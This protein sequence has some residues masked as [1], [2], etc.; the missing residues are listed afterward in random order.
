MDI[1]SLKTQGQK[2]EVFGQI[3]NKSNFRGD[4]IAETVRRENYAGFGVSEEV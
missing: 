1:H 3:Q 2:D 4:G